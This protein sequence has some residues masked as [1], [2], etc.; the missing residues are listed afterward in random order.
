MRT[1]VGPAYEIVTVPGKGRGIRASRDIN[2]DEIVLREF[3]V[4]VAVHGETDLR[5]FFILPEKALEAILL[6]LNAHPN[7]IPYMDD[8]NIPH[9]RL[10]DAFGGILNTN[11]FADKIRG[12]LGLVQLTGSFF[13]HDTSH[14]VKKVWN[15]VT[16]QFVFTTLRNVKRREE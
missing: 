13:N 15:A 2:A 11:A 4:L 8:F 14:N 10:L 5:I 1:P 6:L 12:K 3:S 16:E 9:C 7:K